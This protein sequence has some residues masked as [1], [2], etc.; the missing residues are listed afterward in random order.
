MNPNHAEI[1][2]EKEDLEE[3][4]LK[5]EKEE[6]IGAAPGPDSMAAT[7]GS[8]TGA[9]QDRDISTQMMERTT[10]NTLIMR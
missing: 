1:K 10:D 7:L 3:G 9:T 5:V 8:I 2:A 4:N 6:V